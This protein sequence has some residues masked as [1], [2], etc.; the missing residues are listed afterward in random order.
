VIV[1]FQYSIKPKP[2]ILLKV[3]D[4]KETYRQLQKQG[5][6]FTKVPYQ[7]KTGWAAELQDPA[8]NIIGITD[9]NK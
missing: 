4:V 5:V 3:T 8:G 7:I 9:Y 6:I 1:I 2:S